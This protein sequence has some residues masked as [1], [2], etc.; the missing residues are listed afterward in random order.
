MTATPEQLHAA[1][2]CC[3]DIARTMLNKSGEFY[4]FGAMVNQSGEVEAR[5][6]RTGEE[7]P[8]AR[9]VYSFLLN[10]LRDDLAT[11]KAIAI[12]VASNVNIL[13]YTA[14]NA[15]GLRVALESDGYARLIYVP[16]K[17]SRHGIFF[18]RVADFAEPFAV[19]AR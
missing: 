18:R 13:S 8:G 19:E 16:Y 9:E 4:P 1:L 10:A 6:A 2:M 5:G 11:G 7:H 3:I 14:P 12:A 17:I 15:D